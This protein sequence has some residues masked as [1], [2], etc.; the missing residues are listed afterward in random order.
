MNTD[1]MHKVNIHIKNKKNK[2]TDLGILVF[3]PVELVQ[4]EMPRVEIKRVDERSTG[5]KGPLLLY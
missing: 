3:N 2:K 4:M 1:F 5:C